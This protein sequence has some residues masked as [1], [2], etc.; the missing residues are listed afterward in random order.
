MEIVSVLRARFLVFETPSSMDFNEKKVES[1]RSF[2]SSGDF[3]G[4][5][6]V[7]EIRHR[8]VSRLV[9]FLPR[10]RRRWSAV[11]KEGSDGRCS[12]SSN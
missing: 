9:S 12:I 11:V 7:W 5:R 8:V 6:I 1:V 10:D 3:N 4:V 2:F